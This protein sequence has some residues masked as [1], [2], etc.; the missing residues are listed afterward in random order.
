V[1]LYI[2]LSL[3]LLAAVGIGLLISS[4]AATMQQ[5]VLFNFIVVMPFTLLSGWRRRS[6][7]SRR[8]FNM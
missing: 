1:T 3:F 5:A 2:G 8:F 4:L 6:T 7:T